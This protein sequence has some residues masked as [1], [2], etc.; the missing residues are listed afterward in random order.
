M[1]TRWSVE[2]G[3]RP[4]ALRDRFTRLLPVCTKTENILDTGYDFSLRD[5]RNN[6]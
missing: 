6:F 4:S 1:P 3:G 5:A 2:H